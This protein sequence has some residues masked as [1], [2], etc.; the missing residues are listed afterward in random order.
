MSF[1][2]SLEKARQNAE[3]VLKTYELF[4]YRDIHYISHMTT[5]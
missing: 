4:I 3:A 1:N 5:R 2:L